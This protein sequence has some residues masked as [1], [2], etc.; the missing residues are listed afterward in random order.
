MSDKDQSKAP[1]KS[2][3]KGVHY[4][5]EVLAAGAGKT[6]GSIDRHKKGRGARVT[7][8]EAEAAAAEKQGWVKKVGIKS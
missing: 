3:A 1:E 7:L 2:P 5:C 8:S 6:Y 4:T